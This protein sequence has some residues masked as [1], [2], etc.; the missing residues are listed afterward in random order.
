VEDVV[1][2]I[3]ISLNS[4]LL[5]LEAISKAAQKR[6]IIHKII[7][8]VDLGDLREGIWPDDLLPIVREVVKLPNIRIVGLGTNLSC[9]GG[10]VPTVDNMNQL[11]DLAHQIE[12]RFNLK[13]RYISGGNS[14]SLNLIASGN[15]PKEVNHLRIGEGILLGRETVNRTPWPDTYQDA[16]IL[17]AEVIE[18]KQKPSVPIGEISEDAFGNKP[19]FEDKG[20]MFRA[21][22]NIGRQDVDISGITTVDPR[23]SILGASSDHLLVDVTAAKDEVRVGY[24][25]KFTLNYGALLAAMTSMYVEKRLL[26]EG[27]RNLDF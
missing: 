23:L 1:T 4:E 7:L 21:I 5:V 10:V 18:K 25:L 22:L 12:R 27:S 15:M 9:Y 13:L 14:S 3:E 24:D 20:N 16:F 6:R 17:H 8:M 19:V 2:S 26:K 11:V